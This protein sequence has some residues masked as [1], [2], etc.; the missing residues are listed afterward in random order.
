[1]TDGGNRDPAEDTLYLEEPLLVSWLT[2]DT[3]GLVD[4]RDQDP[5]LEETLLIGEPSLFSWLTGD[6]DGLVDGRDRDPALEETPPLG[7]PSLFSRLIGETE[8]VSS[9]NLRGCFLPDVLSSKGFSIVFQCHCCVWF[10]LFH[11]P[12]SQ[13]IFGS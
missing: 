8:D 9:S 11:G 13:D 7:E 6:T 3:D 2:G 12:K 5:A 10:S 1:M 4:G